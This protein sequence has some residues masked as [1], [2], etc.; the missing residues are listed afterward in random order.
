MNASHLACALI[1]SSLMLTAACADPFTP[2]DTLLSSSALTAPVAGASTSASACPNEPSGWTLLSARS[3][4]PILPPKAVHGGMEKDVGWVST[5]GFSIV[6]DPSAPDGDGWVGQE[7]YTVATRVGSGTMAST[8]L[9]PFA[10]K[11]YKAIY[12]CYMLKV[13]P[14]YI[15]EAS[16]VNKQF[17]FQVGTTAGN[18]IVTVMHI[19]GHPYTNRLP[20][21][22]ALRYQGLANVPSSS[23]IF[24]LKLP[25]ARGSWHR[26]EVRAQLESSKGAADG[27]ITTYSDGKLATTTS[28]LRFTLPGEPLSFAGAKW[29]NTYGGG[30]A[31][32]STANPL[33]G[34][35]PTQAA[36][37]ECFVPHTQYVWIDAQRV[38]V[39]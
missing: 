19:P 35:K 25:V 11:G 34:K 6:P 26:F 3:F 38:L 39:Q 24:N 27:W 31:F 16:G 15:G 14:N 8:L 29:N 23:A 21:W 22:Q 4:L 5:G 37:P 20:M 28:G 9:A 12:T 13:D 30:S 33:T 36:H 17:W 10:G 1:G 18:K 7:T 2:D 32:C